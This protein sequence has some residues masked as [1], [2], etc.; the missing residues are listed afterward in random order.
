[1]KSGSFE[2]FQVVVVCHDTPPAFRIRDRCVGL[3]DVTRP[4]FS[5][6]VASLDRLQVEK[7][8]MPHS[9][10]VVRAIRQMR[11]RTHSPILAGRPPLHFGSN[12]SN[13]RSLNACTT[14]RT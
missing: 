4:M 2:L 13:P 10:G 11:S 12:A 6:W 14:E 5:R 1:M 3:S 8:V 7:L 9:A